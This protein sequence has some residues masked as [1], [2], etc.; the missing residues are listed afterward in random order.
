MGRTGRT[1]QIRRTRSRLVRKADPHGHLPKLDRRLSRPVLPRPPRRLRAAEQL[2]GPAPRGTVSRRGGLPPLPARRH[3]RR[4]NLLTGRIPRQKPFFRV[5]ALPV[6]LHERG[7]RLTR[8]RRG[9]QPDGISGTEA[10]ARHRNR[11]RIRTRHGQPQ[12]PGQHRRKHRRHGHTPGHRCRRRGHQRTLQQRQLLLDGRRQNLLHAPVRNHR[13]IRILPQ[14]HHHPPNP[15]P[16]SS[17]RIRHHL[18]RPR[19]RIR[20]PTG[21]PL[22]RPPQ[23]AHEQ[24]LI[25]G[26]RLRPSAR[27]PIPAEPDPRHHSGCHMDHLHRAHDRAQQPRDGKTLQSQAAD[28]RKCAVGTLHR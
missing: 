4:D 24:L 20:I 2:V 17:L 21:Q 18:S 14:I 8:H 27:K 10:R 3:A 13:R 9:C 12:G 15:L 26:N 25:P 22:R 28:L 11:K 16:G 6:A 1:K 7:L 5:G 19:R 23:P